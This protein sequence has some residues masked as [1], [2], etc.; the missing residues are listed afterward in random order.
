MPLNLFFD[1]INGFQREKGELIFSGRHMVLLVKRR[2]QFK[3][4]SCHDFHM[5]LSRESQN[6]VHSIDLK[7][8][9]SRNCSIIIRKEARTAVQKIQRGLDRTFF[10]ENRLC[11]A[12]RKYPAA[13]LHVEV[14]HHILCLVRTGYSEDVHDWYDKSTIRCNPVET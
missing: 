4:L 9:I 8:D 7:T 12:A 14:I 2:E 6:C 3:I 13:L 11:R 5:L 1:C 10:R